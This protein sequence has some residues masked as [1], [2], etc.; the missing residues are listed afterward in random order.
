MENFTMYFI[1]MVY[2]LSI[3]FLGYLGW[4]KTNDS[5]DFLIGGGEMN[6]IVMALSYGATF[7]S[8]SAIVGFGG[9]AA[10]FGMGI[11][12]LMFLNMFVGVV[13]AFIIFGRP[14]RRLGAKL[15]STSFAQFL[16]SY[17]GSKKIRIFVAS[18]IFIFI[19]L[20][21][22]FELKIIYII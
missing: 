10:T 13:I 2:F 9:V 6:S 14:T 8:A 12:W 19:T 16:G 11:Q 21:N 18:F 4:K 3:A 1:V 5:K 17:Y 20:F 7:I 22:F 15:K